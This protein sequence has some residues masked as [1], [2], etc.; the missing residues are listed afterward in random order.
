MYSSG[1]DDFNIEDYHSPK[2]V[3][4]II[5]LLITN[6]LVTYYDLKY[7]LDIDDMLNLYEICMVNLYNRSIS[8]DNKKHK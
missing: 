7:N 4:G 2:R 8:L 3:S 5:Y 1:S 6:R